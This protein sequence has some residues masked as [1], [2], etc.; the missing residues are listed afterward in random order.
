[1]PGLTNQDLPYTF[2]IAGDLNT[3]IARPTTMFAVP[4]QFELTGA[5]F[6]RNDGVRPFPSIYR[7]HKSQYA[8]SLRWPRI[9]K[10]KN[11]SDDSITL[12]SM[13][14]VAARAMNLIDDSH[15]S[16]MALINWN[17]PLS[18]AVGPT[19]EERRSAEVLEWIQRLERADKVFERSMTLA[20]SPSPF[21]KRAAPTPSSSAGA[22]SVD[23]ALFSSTGCTTSPTSSPS[24]CVPSISLICASPSTPL[25]DSTPG[26]PSLLAPSP[27][28]YCA[29]DLSSS[30]GERTPRACRFSSGVA[31]QALDRKDRPRAARPAT[32]HKRMRSR[33]DENSSSLPSSLSL[34]A[35]LVEQPSKL[36]PPK[37][38]RCILATRS[39]SSLPRAPYTEG[40]SLDLKSYRLRRQ[41][42]LTTLPPRCSFARPLHYWTI[43]PASFYPPSSSN[44]SFSSS[45]FLPTL[46]AVASAAGWKSLDETEAPNS[47]CARGGSVFVASLRDVHAV[48]DLLRRTFEVPRRVRKALVEEV[49]F[50]QLEALREQ[51][52]GIEHFLWD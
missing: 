1:M 44:P 19:R 16:P 21:D 37:I 29:P 7:T 52:R 2:E 38:E 24:L 34:P 27:T 13:C 3:A 10:Y 45:N 49:R 48:R 17:R 5:G 23:D 40:G 8:Y 25:V 22:T 33:G 11:R 42:S 41:S 9:T 46:D 15:D 35:P 4:F 50:F 30:V 6:Q 14:K 18:C 32:R 28:S 36:V 47:L 26:P 51:G 12:A 39:E 20:Y 31:D 43:Y